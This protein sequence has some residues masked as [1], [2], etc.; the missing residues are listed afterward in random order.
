MAYM[1]A[2]T[3]LMLLLDVASVA[4]CIL[5]GRHVAVETPK[6]VNFDTIYVLRQARSA[7]P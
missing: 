2:S 7:A 5:H 4:S 3:L 6:T 1:C